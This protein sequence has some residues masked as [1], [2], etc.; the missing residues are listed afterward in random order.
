MRTGFRCSL[1]PRMRRPLT[2]PRNAMRIA[3]HMLSPTSIPSAS[4]L[5]IINAHYRFISIYTSPFGA[6]CA[7]R[8]RAFYRLSPR[9]WPTNTGLPHD[10]E[11]RV[12]YRAAS[13]H[14]S[15]YRPFTCLMPQQRRFQHSGRQGAPRGAAMT[16]AGRPLT[17]SM[18]AVTTTW[19]RSM[20]EG[21]QLITLA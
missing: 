8:R 21:Y 7:C 14:L 13:S 3:S 1:A 11:R 15:S 2:P 16:T 12:S 18:V 10:Y 5:T 19:Q 17:P 4:I 20:P 6:R 9:R